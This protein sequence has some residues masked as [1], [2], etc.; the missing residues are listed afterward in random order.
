[1]DDVLQY[2]GKRVIVTGAA[3]GTGAATTALLVELG[4]EVHV[5][6]RRRSAQRE[7]ASFT[8]TDL[9]EPAQIDAA[10]DRI[11]SV[12]N[13]LFHCADA[14]AVAARHLVERVVERMVEGAAIVT[15]A[16]PP[17][18]E[19]LTAYVVA[20]AVSLAPRG[21]RI[22]GVAAA[23]DADAPGAD[24][25]AWT[26]LFLNSPRASAVTGIVLPLSTPA[27]PA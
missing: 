14:G 25:L 1:M 19:D 24:A 22:N 16:G 23:A 21:V 11:G 6:D 9:R 7:L 13:G 17:P 10:V 4:A 12:V 27:Q 26:L 5:I 8:E 18:A 3:A 2:A 15:G 20:Q